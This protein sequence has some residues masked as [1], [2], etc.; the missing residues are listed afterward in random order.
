MVTFA[1]SG[2]AIAI[3]AIALPALDL[4]ILPD[5]ADKK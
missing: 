1:S 3:R 4:Y 5:N 2:K